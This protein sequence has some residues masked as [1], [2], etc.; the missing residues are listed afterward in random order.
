LEQLIKEGRITKD[1]V[2]DHGYKFELMITGDK[3]EVTAVPVEYGK[4]GKTSYFID[5]SNVLRGADHAGGPA[6]AADHP[7]RN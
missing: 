1:A 2:E 4:T 3:F 5:Q 6:T 7:I